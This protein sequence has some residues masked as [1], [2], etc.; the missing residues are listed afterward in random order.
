MRYSLFFT[1]ALSS[2]AL[3]AP[4]PVGPTDFVPDNGTVHLSSHHKFAGFPTGIPG[5]RLKVKPRRQNRRDFSSRI[6]GARRSRRRTDLESFSSYIP[7]ARVPSRRSPGSDETVEA[8]SLLNSFGKRA[9]APSADDKDPSKQGG[10]AK[11]GKHGGSGKTHKHKKGGKKGAKG[12]GGKGGDK[13][14]SGASY[15]R[16]AELE[17]TDTMYGQLSA[18]ALKRASRSYTGRKVMR[19]EGDSSHFPKTGKAS[20]A[21]GAT[22]SSADGEPKK[23][24]VSLATKVKIVTTMVKVVG[25][26]MKERKKKAAA[27]TPAAGDAGTD[28]GAAAPASSKGGSL[29]SGLAKLGAA[30]KAKQGASGVAD[31]DVGMAPAAGDAGS[32]AGAAAPASSKGGSL[33]SGLAKLGAAAKAKQGASGAADADAGMAP[34]AG[35]AGSDAGTAAPST[36]KGGSLLSGLA[37][38]AKG[39]KGAGTAA[40]TTP[41]AE[42]ASSAA[43]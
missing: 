37:K 9:E 8:V 43:T 13:S 31:G 39:K 3:A 34:A 30:A 36:G 7:G 25:F 35:D 41:E 20:T 17:N 26:V 2:L 38:L 5:D 18:R 6:P 16:H 12:A 10:K 4:A 23:K 22:G 15:K 1:L 28:T 14:A 24:G 33:L 21:K 11:G 40:T 42:G 29:L 27:A 32:D 19:A